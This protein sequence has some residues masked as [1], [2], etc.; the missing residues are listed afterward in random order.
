MKHC[1]NCP[2][3]ENLTALEVF[4]LFDEGTENED[5]CLCPTCLKQSTFW[6]EIHNCQKVLLFDPDFQ[7]EPGESEVLNA[8]PQCM[9][10]RSRSLPEA[11]AKNICSLLEDLADQLFLDGLRI[12]ST[13]FIQT[14][15]TDSERYLF[16]MVMYAELFSFEFKECIS[17]VVVHLHH[18]TIH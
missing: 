11:D 6:C 4:V 14:E 16:V 13:E 7:E 10:E 5:V 18:G 15:L 9:L 2:A 17:Q 8:C 1:H 12:L 3:Q